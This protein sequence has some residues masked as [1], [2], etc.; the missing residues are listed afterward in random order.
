VANSGAER[1][2]EKNAIYAAAVSPP[3]ANAASQNVAVP[4]ELILQ[5]CNSPQENPWRLRNP[6]QTSYL[7]GA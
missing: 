7:D 3:Q 1:H 2:S 4:S 6:Q 5:E